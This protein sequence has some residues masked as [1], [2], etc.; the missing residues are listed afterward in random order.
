MK[1]IILIAVAALALI[2]AGSAAASISMHGRVVETNGSG[3]AYT[4]NCYAIIWQ[5][6]TVDFWGN[7]TNWHVYRYVYIAPGSNG[8]W[9]TTGLPTSDPPGDWYA[10]YGRNYYTNSCSGNYYLYTDTFRT[11]RVGWQQ[12]GYDY[13]TGT[14]SLYRSSPNH[15]FGAALAS[16]DYVC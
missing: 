2:G 8:Y 7:P 9:S 5:A 6:N 13:D 3:C 14:R 10:E 15:N 1:R 16:P 4:A 12:N 11:G